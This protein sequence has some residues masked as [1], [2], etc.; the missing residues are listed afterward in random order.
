M[1]E[2]LM[3]G[4]KNIFIGT[5]ISYKDNPAE[6]GKEAVEMALKNSQ[7][8]KPEFVIIFAS[9]KK[10]GTEEK[11]NLLAKAVDTYLTSINQNIKWVGAS[12]KKEISNYGYT[13]GSVVAM[14][15]NSPYVH[16]GVG[17]GQ[18]VTKNSLKAGEQAAEN[19]ISNVK[20][21]SYLDPYLHFQA[22]KTQKV[23]DILRMKPYF[24]MTL[25]PGVTKKYLPQDSQVLKGITNIV[26]AHPLFGGDA[27]DDWTLTQTFTIAN[28][29]VYKDAVVIACIVSNL[30][31]NVGVKHGYERTNMV[32]VVTKA[33]GGVI[34]ELNNKPAAQEYARLTNVAVEE[35][36]KDV[37]PT[38][39]RNPMGMP[40]SQGEYWLNFPYAVV[41]KDALA[42]YEPIAEGTAL[43]IMKA[44]NQQI[45]D[46]AKTAIQNATNN[47]KEIEGLIVLSCS[48]RLIALGKDIEKEYALI[49]K[50]VKD[51]PFIGFSC[52]AEHA[53]V[54]SGSVQKH[55]YT[56]VTL[57]LTN[58]LI[59]D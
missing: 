50:V 29:V 9:A 17:V 57:G 52:Y 49:K 45:V 40:D 59:S 20:L 28:G 25:F 15:I 30:Q 10:Y 55:A 19:A 32:M 12:S 22:I 23:G 3:K 13:E 16:F 44:N 14:V 38:L 18:N 56:F 47:L 27:A 7:S 53:T 1:I 36:R 46:A 5:G 35:L 54:P 42:F 34:Y 8:Q 11:M 37:I 6:A 39:S 41:E 48:A 58:K 2:K 33:K 21:D 31:F 24:F 43:F 51:K 4:K 26:G